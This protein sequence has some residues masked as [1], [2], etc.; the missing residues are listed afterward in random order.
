[1]PRQPEHGG[2]EDVPPP[3]LAERHAQY[4]R[5]A[6]WTRVTRSHMVRRARLLQAERVLD[7]GCGSG[8][9]TRELAR[10]T[11]GHVTG[12]DR[13]AE[14]IAFARQQGGRILYKEGDA[15]ALPYPDD[16]FDIA[17][18]HFVLMWVA[19]PLQA[20][21]EMARVVRPGGFVL[22]C[23]E[24]DYGGRLDWPE[25]PIGRWQV[26]GLRRQGADPLLGRRLRQLSAAAGLRADVGII[27]S[28]WDIDALRENWEQEWTWLARDVRLRPSGSGQDEP[29]AIVSPSAFASAQNQARAAIEEGTRLV[30]IPIFY[31]V[32][33]K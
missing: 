15:L 13:D 20:V 14:M 21:R 33:S 12:L 25:L 23:G 28:H 27:P 24:P 3:T 17:A 11:R 10:R 2:L 18:C 32:D 7:V 5:Q 29:A 1:M 30:F 22:L 26:E 19:D 6:E 8:V 31:A 9:I 4:L 16:Y